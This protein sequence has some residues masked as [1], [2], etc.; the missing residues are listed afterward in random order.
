MSLTTIVL[1]LAGWTSA[2]V[3]AWRVRSLDAYDPDTGSDAERL[4]VVVPARDEAA[5]LPRLLASL[6]DQTLPPRAVVVVDDSSTDGTA[7]AATAMGATV[8]SAPE[9]PRGWLGKPWACHLGAQRVTGRVAFL[10]ADTWLAPDGLARLAAAHTAL[11]PD[12]LLSVQPH[13]HVER[14]DEHLSLL[15]NI[16]PVLA[17][18]MFAPRPPTQAGP[19]VAFGPCLVTDVD[20]LRVVGGFEA[21]RGEVVEDVALAAAFRRSGRP[22]VCR[23]GGGVV[24]FRMYPDGVRQLAEG[25][26]K[27]LAQGATRAPRL[28]ALGAV[29]WVAA[30]VAVAA[31]AVLHPGLAVATAWG[32]TIVQVAWLARR[33]GTYRLW[34]A[35]LFPIPLAAF[36]ALF[37]RSLLRRLLRR[38]VRWRGR[39]VVT[40]RSGAA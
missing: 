8:V 38:P 14:A 6:A 18:G 5:T 27:N 7:A 25:W 31:E 12:G 35:A 21:V 3:L 2:T 37:A 15:G 9:P 26:T 30:L 24:M 19:V 16:V 23:A 4:T 10:D 36:V 32:I 13:H 34:A 11:A 33:V 40:T 22:V 1:L 29:L 28:P 39:D 17:S 20:D